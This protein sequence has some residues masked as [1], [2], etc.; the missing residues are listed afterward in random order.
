MSETYFNTTNETGDSLKQ[1]VDKA[2]KQDE[3]IY[4]FFKQNRHNNYTPYEIFKKLFTSKTPI[5]SIR[6]SITNLTA[7]NK[8]KQLETQRKGG[9]GK[10]NYCWQF[11]PT[12]A[13]IELQE[14]YAHAIIPSGDKVE[15]K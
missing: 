14:K 6:R 13:D 15:K 2:K 9:F 1:S 12:Q 5:T 11:A 4:D 8:L 7:S 3:I 10:L